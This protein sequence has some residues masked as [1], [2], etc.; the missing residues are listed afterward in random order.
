MLEFENLIFNRSIRPGEGLAESECEKYRIAQLEKTHV[1][2]F[3]QLE[4][5]L[6]ISCQEAVL[7]MVAGR[8]PRGL[9]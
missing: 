4:G 9:D 5:I 6:K 1:I 8:N 7:H 3:T 2:F